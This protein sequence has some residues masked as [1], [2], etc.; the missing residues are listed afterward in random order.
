MGMEAQ[1]F[2]GFGTTFQRPEEWNED[3]SPDDLDLCQTPE[4]GRCSQTPARILALA[5]RR[6]CEPDD[7]QTIWR[8]WPPPRNSSPAATRLTLVDRADESDTR[9]SSA[10]HAEAKRPTQSPND[11]PHSDAQTSPM[12]LPP[13]RAVHRCTARGSSL[14]CEICFRR[15]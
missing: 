5:Q 2:P 15:A 11:P 6:F 4:A 12:A 8:M 13:Q 7:L 14:D 1:T 10:D 9:S 3:Q